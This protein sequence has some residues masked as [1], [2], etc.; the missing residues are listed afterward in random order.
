MGGVGSAAGSYDLVYA[1]G[2][3][4][5][6]GDNN[7]FGMVASDRYDNMI[8]YQTPKFA[9]LQAT[10]QYSFKED[11]VNGAGT[12]GKSSA[13][14]YAGAAVTGEFGALNTVFAYEFENRVGSLTNAGV[15]DG[16][17]F[18]LGANYDCGF[19]TTYAM[20]QYF[21]GARSG[22]GVDALGIEKPFNLVKGAD[23]FGLHL[24]TVVPVAGGEFTAG[25]Y[26]MDGEA[27]F[28]QANLTADL[29]YYGA[30]A[31]YVYPLSKR[32]SLYAG[33]G[34]GYTEA[35]V[36]TYKADGSVTQAYVGLTHKF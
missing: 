1:I 28:L 16:H 25:L 32:T 7:V 26:Y 10:V 21:E 19:A 24:G 17:T 2:D 8:T 15:D 9:G 3:S 36:E 31:R 29:Q 22:F 13:N 5:D 18:Y 33:A 14:R 12:E 27:D 23:G 11:S 34:Y 6:G 4:F 20:V 35:E 30:S